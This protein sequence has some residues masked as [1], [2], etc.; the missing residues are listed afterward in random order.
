MFVIAGIQTV[1]DR[2]KKLD[3]QLAE[4]L[5]CNFANKGLIS[6]GKKIAKNF[7]KDYIG[8]F[9]KQYNTIKEYSCIEKYIDSGG[10]QIATQQIPKKYIDKYTDT[11]VKFLETN[12]FDYAF[13]LDIPDNNEYKDVSELVNLNRKA[14]DK[15]VASNVDK[16]KI[17]FVVHFRTINLFEIWK[18][19]L[20]YLDHFH[21]VAI[22]GLVV[23]QSN[24]KN[25]PFI[26]SITG[27]M[28]I[29]HE[30]KQKNILKTKFHVL[31]N[32]TFKDV[33]LYTLLQKAVK[34]FYNIDFILTYD[35]SNLFKKFQQARFMTYWDQERE[36]A[37][38]VSAKENELN[39]RRY[40]GR[41]SKDILLEEVYTMAKTINYDGKFDRIYN[42]EGKFDDKISPFLLLIE[43]YQQIKF[44]KW[45]E[46]KVDYYYNLYKDN[47]NEFVIELQK[48]LFSIGSKNKKLAGII[49]NTLDMLKMDFDIKTIE[50]LLKSYS[51]VT[52]SEFL[53][54]PA[55]FS[56]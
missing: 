10:Y 54:Q 46:K 23:A 8:S 50:G 48:L 6:F 53:D 56:I 29:L 17:L 42:D 7:P 39:L 5:V 14:M 52:D 40:N 3:R 18:N 36:E 28:M 45:M 44:E 30:L 34:D 47:P 31:G 9:Y 33:V 55:Q 2:F 24:M 51:I 35:S 32:S 21:N 41:S 11:Y 37:Y 13:S 1:T 27:I 38:Q 20:D 22:G 19:L 43:S 49:K 15:I 16:N 12:D 26:F 4:S 25:L